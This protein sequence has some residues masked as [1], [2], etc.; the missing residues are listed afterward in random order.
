[1]GIWSQ[2]IHSYTPQVIV[3]FSKLPANTLDFLSHKTEKKYNVESASM[4]I[5][6]L[7]REFSECSR[8]WG[9]IDAEMDAQL[10]GMLDGLSDT[11]EMVF[12]CDYDLFT[13]YKI[14]FDK[15]KNAVEFH[16]KFHLNSRRGGPRVGGL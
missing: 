14:R 4:T 11:A 8:I 3:D 5:D 12:S 2:Y 1:M 15:L 7:G 16:L 13:Y 10:H 6:S 9:Y